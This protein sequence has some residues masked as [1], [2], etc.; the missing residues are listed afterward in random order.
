[1]PKVPTLD[2]QRVSA[3]GFSNT[4]FSIKTP[5]GAFGNRGLANVT[6]KLA[7]EIQQFAQKEQKMADY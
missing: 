6:D 5:A 2:G 7:G 1:M 4:D 3:T